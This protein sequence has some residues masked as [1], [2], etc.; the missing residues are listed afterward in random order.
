MHCEEMAETTFK[1][2][3]VG[4]SALSDTVCAD[5]P[6][7]ENEQYPKSEAMFS[8]STTF[9]Y[10]LLSGK[11]DS[12]EE[13]CS[14]T[15]LHNYCPTK[16]QLSYK[17]M[18]LECMKTTKDRDGVNKNYLKEKIPAVFGLEQNVEFRRKLGYSL[19]QLFKAV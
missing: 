19:K 6:N 13:N 17:F 2:Y 4:G 16:K 5:R 15:D 10:P 12:S 9:N 11:E 7:T 3:S 14:S 18:I 1:N 8:T